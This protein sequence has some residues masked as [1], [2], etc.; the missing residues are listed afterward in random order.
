MA[1]REGEL[2]RA[3]RSPGGSAARSSTLGLAKGFCSPL[4]VDI[5]I[6]N[7]H[8]YTHGSSKCAFSRCQEQPALSQA[9]LTGGGP[10][11]PGTPQPGGASL[12]LPGCGLTPSVGA[13]GVGWCSC[14]QI[15]V[16]CIPPP[17]PTAFHGELRGAPLTG[18]QKLSFT[19]GGGCSGELGGLCLGE[20]EEEEAAASGYT[21]APGEQHLPAPA[22][23]AF[24]SDLLGAVRGWKGFLCK[25]A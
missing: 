3:A 17:F 8:I 4:P 21:C 10:A 19:R 9:A 24:F 23:R 15:P 18:Q 11:P 22:F 2:R 20:D 25:R 7:T 16:L 12:E 5:V 13:A 1:A 14:C 6:I